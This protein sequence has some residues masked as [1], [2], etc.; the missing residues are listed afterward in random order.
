MICASKKHQSN[1]TALSKAV[2]LVIDVGDVHDEVNIIA[3]VVRHDPSQDVLRHVV[4]G[5]G[6]VH[7]RKMLIARE[8]TSHVPCVTHRRPW[9]RS[10]TTSH[11]APTRGRTPSSSAL[12]IIS[13]KPATARG[14]GLLFA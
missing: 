10:C 3:K 12:Q 14:D 13:K 4:S 6:P 1:S 8:L 7:R 2:H 9:A 11:G 5:G